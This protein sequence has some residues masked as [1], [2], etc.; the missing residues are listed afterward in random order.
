VATLGGDTEKLLFWRDGP[1]DG[2]PPYARRDVKN[3]APLLAAY[4]LL[5]VR[6]CRSVRRDGVVMLAVRGRPG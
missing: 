5:L 1:A 6:L 3:A 2:L 4:R